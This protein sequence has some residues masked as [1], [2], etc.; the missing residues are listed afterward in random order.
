MVGSLLARLAHDRHAQ[1]AP[2]DA[3]DVPERH[4]PPRPGLPHDRRAA[5]LVLIAKS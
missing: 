3:G 2:D 4:A 5:P 1:A